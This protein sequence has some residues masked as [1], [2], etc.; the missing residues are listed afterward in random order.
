M[1]L[2]RNSCV[3][4]IA[5]LFGSIGILSGQAGGS[6]RATP[7]STAWVA[8]ALSEMLT[9]KPGMTR[10]QLLTVFT[11]EGGISTRLHRTFVSRV[12]PYFKV[13][14]EF[15]PEG[16]TAR[17]REG[18]LLAGEDARDVIEKISQPFLQFSHMD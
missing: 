7:E 18:R 1:R 6:A 8:S 11:T 5:L 4:V 17:D 10:G 16:Q 2:F 12:C 9:I 3:A 13:E 14:V 15:R